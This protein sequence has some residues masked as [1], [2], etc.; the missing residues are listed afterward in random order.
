V[1]FAYWTVDELTEA[2]LEALATGCIEGVPVEADAEILASRLGFPDRVTRGAEDGGGPHGRPF[3]Q[4]YFASGLSMTRD[5]ECVTAFYSRDDLCAP[6]ECSGITIRAY[7]MD[8]PPQW[9]AL[10]EELRRY[11]YG[12]ESSWDG[13]SADQYTVRASAVSA[14]VATDDDFAATP[15]GR[16]VLVDINRWVV[17]PS[18]PDRRGHLRN[19]MRALGRAG[20]GA[21]S[22]WL[23]EQ[24]RGPDAFVAVFTALHRLTADQPAR[25][26]EW[27][28][29]LTWFLEQAREREVFRPE[30]WVYH[31]ARFGAP[32]RADVSRACLDVLPMTL[33]EAPSLPKNWRDTE[34]DT[35]RRARMTRALLH[36]AAGAAPDPASVRELDRWRSTMRSWLQ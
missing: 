30:E 8:E 35:A 22:S 7:L 16:L 34:P 26:D 31:W 13:S 27:R 6:W 36:L 17:P 20:T 28:S 21:W 23:A 2:C 5:W 11:G 32:P 18:D 3:E 19:A 29:L 1:E 4:R 33:D 12:P 15:A 10:D 25:A 14:K 24:D 9:S